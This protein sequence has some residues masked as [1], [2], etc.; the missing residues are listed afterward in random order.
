MY[1]IG[2]FQLAVEQVFWSNYAW[3][4]TILLDRFAAFTQSEG[5]PVALASA[6]P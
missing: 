2:I 4:R 6:V 1:I 3:G 5:G